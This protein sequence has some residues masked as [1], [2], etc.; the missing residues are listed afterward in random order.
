VTYIRL[1]SDD[2]TSDPTGK[3]AWGEGEVLYL[4]FQVIDTGRGMSEEELRLLFHKFTQA[5][6]KTHAR[7]CYTEA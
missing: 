2:T 5:S 4:N 1:A 7:K 6:P 3:S